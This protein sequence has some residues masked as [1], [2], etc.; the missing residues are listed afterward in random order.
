GNHKLIEPN[1]G[2]I[3]YQASLMVRLNN[4]YYQTFCGGSLIHPQWVLTAAHCL[5]QNN[6]AMP[7]NA[8]YITL[9]SI[10][11][12]GRGGQR[13]QVERL[14]INKKYLESGIADI[15]L[16]KLKTPARLGKS[17][18]VIKLHTNQGESLI[19]NTA[20]LTGYGIINDFYQQPTRLRKAVLH[21]NTPDKCL[22]DSRDDATEICC[23]STISEGKAC[24]VIKLFRVTAGL[25]T[26]VPALEKS[27]AGKMEVDSIKEVFQRSE[28]MHNVKYAQYIGDGDSKTSKAKTL[29]LDPYNNDPKVM[30]KER[31]GHVKK[32]AWEPSSVMRRKQTRDLGEEG[33]SGGPLTILKNGRYIQV[34]ITSHLAILPFCK[35][36]FNNSVY[37]RVSAYIAWISKI[38]GIDFMKYNPS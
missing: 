10:Y 2:D 15:G 27:H 30:K 26:T 32:N 11:T 24:K 35:I 7:T 3:P 19:G 38:T 34:G 5:E 16:V 28:E 33:D 6:K 12:N 9:G 36:S 22:M 29:D 23:T 37:T 31:V 14:A 1:L 13:L 8:I 20:Y 18:K 17:V 25:V 21:I 4:S